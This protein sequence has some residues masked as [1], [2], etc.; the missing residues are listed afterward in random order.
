[1]QKNSHTRTLGC[2]FYIFVLLF[3]SFT[4][5]TDEIIKKYVMQKLPFNG[6]FFEWS[7]FSVGLHK[8]FGIAF[9][10][11]LAPV[12]VLVISLFFV[13]LLTHIALKHL[14]THPYISLGAALIVIG[15]LGNLFDRLMYGFTVDYL[16]FFKTSAL[17]LS[18]FVILT[19]TLVLL[20]ASR[21]KKSVDN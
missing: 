17:N 15:A 14:R 11:P 18:D 21:V 7:F 16:L 19:G 20:F 1:M 8:N 5:L 9:D 13:A 10:I 2:L 6:E 3:A 12:F 4:V